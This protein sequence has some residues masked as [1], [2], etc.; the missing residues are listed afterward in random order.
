MVLRR[1]SLVVGR[2]R[3]EAT[4]NRIYVGIAFVYGALA[5]GLLLWI[6]ILLADIDHRMLGSGSPLVP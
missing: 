2:H 5:L 1:W 4:M 3:V 6:A